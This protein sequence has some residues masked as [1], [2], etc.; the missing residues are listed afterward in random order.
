[1]LLSSLEE[2][3]NSI[4]RFRTF[5]YDRDLVLV[6][7]DSIQFDSRR[8]KMDVIFELR[9]VR[10]RYTHMLSHVFIYPWRKNTLKYVIVKKN[11]ARDL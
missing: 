10:L 6:R 2:K 11:I 4:F 5:N 9:K 1:M 8:L 7:M 3:K